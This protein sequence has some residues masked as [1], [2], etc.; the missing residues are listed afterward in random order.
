MHLSSIY[1]VVYLVYLIAKEND[2]KTVWWVAQDTIFRQWTPRNAVTIKYA[3]SINLCITMSRSSRVWF[4]LGGIAVLRMMI[5]RT[6]S[7]GQRICASI[8][9]FLASPAAQSWFTSSH[10]F[11]RVCFSR[12]RITFI[13][14][15]A[16][17]IILL[18]RVSEYSGGR[19]RLEMYQKWTLL[20][21]NTENTSNRSWTV[22]VLLDFSVRFLFYKKKTY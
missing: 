15:I 16:V 17:L 18:G 1:V 21:K 6:F 3:T 13:C 2:E 8:F 10:W 7:S 19:V 20:G 5:S 9:Q 12:V 14:N 22:F 11:G 4:W